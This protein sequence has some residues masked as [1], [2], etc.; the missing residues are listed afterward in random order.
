M[1][2]LLLVALPS[3]TERRAT[4]LL[5]PSSSST[6]IRTPPI[7]S[8]TLARDGAA[9]GAPAADAF[10]D[11][12]EGSKSGD[13]AE[14]PSTTSRSFSFSGPRRRPPRPGAWTPAFR[15]FARPSSAPRVRRGEGAEE[16]EREKERKKERTKER[17]KERKKE[18][19]GSEIA[20]KR[21][22]RLR[23]A[24]GGE[25]KKKRGQETFSASPI[26]KQRRRAHESGGFRVPVPR[27]QVRRRG[28]P[29]GRRRRVRVEVAAAAAGSVCR[30][31]SSTSTSTPT[32]RRRFCSSSAAAA[33]APAARGQQAR[34]AHKTRGASSSCY[35]SR[36]T[37]FG[38][39]A[40]GPPLAAGAA[41]PLRRRASFLRRSRR[42]FH[43]LA[44]TDVAPP[45]APPAELPHALPEV[46]QQSRVPTRV[47]VDAPVPHPLERRAAALVPRLFRSVRGAAAT[48]AAAAAHPQQVPD[49]CHV[50]VRIKD[51]ALGGLAVSLIF[52][53]GEMTVQ[54]RERERE[55]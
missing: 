4:P 30:G 1:A 47:G 43:H 7:R 14:T 26:P 42:L 49:P 20:S 17:T 50:P 13:D 21:K 27:P 12:S 19:K 37:S 38:A 3:S 45:A 15:G 32:R 34:G 29:Q 5:L 54:E 52:F 16:E 6:E 41:L 8:S 44:A 55:R 2:F 46:P 36:F 53:E 18:G 28:G 40:R 24:K 11:V 35:S 39:F 31:A 10:G 9:L 22:T 23:G 48:C 51:D 25:E 33:P